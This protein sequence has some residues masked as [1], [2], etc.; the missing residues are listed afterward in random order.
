MRTRVTQGVQ[1][2]RRVR[3]FV[4]VREVKPP[5]GVIA[6]HVEELDG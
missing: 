5:L 1:V 6:K 4:A 2:F 3:D